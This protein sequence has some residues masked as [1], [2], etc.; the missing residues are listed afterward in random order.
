MSLLPHLIDQIIFAR[1]YTLRILDRIPA[2]DWFAIPGS[3]SHIAWQVGHLAMA[4]YRLALDRVR[5]PLPGDAALISDE[6]LNSFGRGSVAEPDP[7]KNPPVDKIRSVFDSVHQQTL[8]ELRGMPNL[9]LDAPVIK[10]HSLYTT[11]AEILRWR[12]HHEML[13]AG[14]IGLIRRLLGAKPI[15]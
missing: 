8:A 10:P 5:G 4:E 9:D 3:V 15:W 14:Q 7:A 12:S 1:G 11:K 13:H 6:F 2:S